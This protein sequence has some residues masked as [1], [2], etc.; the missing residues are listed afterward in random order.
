MFKYLVFVIPFILINKSC[1]YDEN[2]YYSKQV[3][4][5]VVERFILEDAFKKNL[6]IAYYLH[7]DCGFEK[8]Q[9]E[10]IKQAIEDGLWTWLEPLGKVENRNGKKIIRAN[11]GRMAGR[12]MFDGLVID[13]D[14][15]SNYEIVSP[16][17]T[18]YKDNRIGKYVVEPSKPILGKE[19]RRKKPTNDYI[20][21]VHIYCG[22]FNVR[23]NEMGVGGG[24]TFIPDPKGSSGKLGVHIYLLPPNSPP[25]IY[26]KLSEDQ[27]LI[28]DA[29][30][31]KDFL[32]GSTGIS[33]LV[34]LHEL[35][36]VLGLEHIFAPETIMCSS[37][38]QLPKGNQPNQFGFPQLS[39][40]DMA[41]IKKEYD[42]HFILN[43]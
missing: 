22:L 10:E 17:P 28:Y 3:A 14:P 16:S 29:I 1:Q 9:S 24:R 36:H 25:L 5:K 32:V 7:P 6:K 42:K 43:K 18:I 33:K 38:P 15:A 8:K 23:T 40:K 34:L 31:R 13:E 12:V 20:F 26:E 19:A 39:D 4:N 30:P 27:K 2:L 21:T 11:R 35:G 41:E 37:V